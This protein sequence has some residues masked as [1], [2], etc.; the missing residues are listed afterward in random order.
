MEFDFGSTTEE[1][2]DQLGDG[3]PFLTCQEFDRGFL[4]CINPHL[5]E[6][7]T[8]LS[9]PSRPTFPSLCHDLLPRDLWFQ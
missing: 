5:D 6:F 4:F 2:A 1:L 8:E 7:I 9:H 3:K